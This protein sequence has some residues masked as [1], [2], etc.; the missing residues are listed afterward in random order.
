MA[1]LTPARQT[2]TLKSSPWSSHSLI[3]DLFPAPGNGRKVL[4]VGCWNGMLA[5]Q[6]ADRGYDVTGIE[7]VQWARGE[8]PENVKLIHAELHAGLPSL[9]DTYDYIIC[10]DVLEHLLDPALVLHK[11]GTYLNPGGTLIASLPNSGNIYFRLVILSGHFPKEDKGLF[12]RTHVHFFTWDGWSQLFRQSGFH[13]SGVSPSGIPV[14]L[15]FPRAEGSWLLHA[16]DR[17]AGALARFWKTLFAYQ[18]VVT[19]RTNG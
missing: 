16:L 9:F 8:F 4:D 6:I 19:A 2:Y 13:I 14:G 18:F 3:L 17:F 5:G 15:Q 12:D 10:A 1:T 11:L 7:K